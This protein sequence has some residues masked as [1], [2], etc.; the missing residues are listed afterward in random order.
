MHNRNLS[1]L[2]ETRLDDYQEMQEDSEYFV[3]PYI[4]FYPANKRL[5]YGSK[6]TRLL[7]ACFLTHL[8][9]HS[10]GVTLPL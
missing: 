6:H 5:D 2:P 10:N 4:S 7:S 9:F 8:G 3:R 1:K